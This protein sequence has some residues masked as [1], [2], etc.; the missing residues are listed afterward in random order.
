MFHNDSRGE[1]RVTDRWVDAWDSPVAGW[2]VC[3]LRD[4]ADGTTRVHRYEPTYVHTS[5]EY[6][7]LHAIYLRAARALGA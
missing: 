4:Y 7:A 6:A 1:Y 2:C 5:P 3:E